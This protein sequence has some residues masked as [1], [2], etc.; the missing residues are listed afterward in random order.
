M[1]DLLGDIKDQSS[2]P[3]LLDLATQP[4]HAALRGS[5]RLRSA[6]W[7]GLRTMRSPRPCWRRI[8]IR[9][10]TGDRRPASCS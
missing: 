2:V 5:G 9:V 8:R 6:R 4:A 1:L 10:K 7:L 3:L